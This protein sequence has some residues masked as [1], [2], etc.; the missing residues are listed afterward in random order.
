MNSDHPVILALREHTRIRPAD[1]D[2]LIEHGR[3]YRGTSL[4]PGVRRWPLGECQIGAQVMADL[5]L[6]ELVVGFVLR[7]GERRPFD[8][9]WCSPD[10]S[11]A[12]DPTLQDPR[13]NEYVGLH[14]HHRDRI[15]SIAARVFQGAMHAGV[16]VDLMHG[17]LAIPGLQPFRFR[18]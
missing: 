9:H 10:G 1:L 6:G 14:H 18:L 2:F 12:Y 15:S 17:G 16:P 11:R 3:S 8:H 5:G 13:E 4:P 7:P